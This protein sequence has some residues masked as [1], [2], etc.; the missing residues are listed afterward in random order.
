MSCPDQVFVRLPQHTVQ[1]MNG[2]NAIVSHS[3]CTGVDGVRTMSTETFL[4]DVLSETGQIVP[5]DLNDPAYGRTS[6]DI[7]ESKLNAILV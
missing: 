5:F 4:Q 3:T 2:E 1:V 6:A 7:D